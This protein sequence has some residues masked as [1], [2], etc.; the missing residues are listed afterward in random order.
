M[1]PQHSKVTYKSIQHKEVN[2]LLAG[3]YE[4]SSP[5]DFKKEYYLIHDHSDKSLFYETQKVADLHS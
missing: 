3:L 1:K 5:T 2:L 4:F